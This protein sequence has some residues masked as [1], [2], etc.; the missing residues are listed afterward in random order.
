VEEYSNAQVMF[1]RSLDAPSFP[2]SRAVVAL[3][4]VHFDTKD[5]VKILNNLNMKIRPGEHVA[6]VGPS[7]CGKSTA[8]DLFVRN[9]EPTKGSIRADNTPLL[10]YDF[11]SLAK[12]TSIV[13]QKPVLFNLSLRENLLLGLRSPSEDG[14]SDIQTDV[15]T[16]AFD[17]LDGDDRIS[18]SI[19]KIIEK[20]GLQ[21]DMLKKAF[22]SP[23]P[24]RLKEGSQV[25]K[26]LRSLKEKIAKRLS[27][28]DPELICH[29][30]REQ[31]LFESSLRE[32]ILFGVL[33]QDRQDE[34]LGRAVCTSTKE[35]F[36]LLKGSPLLKSLLH[37]GHWR[38]SRDHSVAIRVEQHSSKL[39][40]ILKA[41]ESAADNAGALA[42]GLDFLSNE[43]LKSFGKLKEKDK[44]LL[45]EI[46]L[47]GNSREAALHF[48]GE[49]RFPPQIV[50]SRV[51]AASDSNLRALSVHHFDGEPAGEYL[52]LG[53]SFIGGR[54][55]SEFR[56][57]RDEVDGAIIDVMKEEGLIDELVLMGLEYTAGEG[58]G[59]LSGGQA[60][61]IAIARSILKDPSILLMDEAT[62]PLD[63]KSQA[64]V[65]SVIE[66]EF[67][68]RT[69]IFI[70]HRISTVRNFDRILVFDRGR[71]VQEG[72]YDELV[73]Q[74]GL[75]QTLVR[76]QEGA[77]APAP[78]MATTDKEAQDRGLSG[79]LPAKSSELKR[80][81]AMCPVF[82]NLKI[83][84]IT[85]LERLAKI[86][87]CTE[88]RVLFSRGDPADEFFII[89]DGEVEFIVDH[90]TDEGSQ[91]EIVDTYGPGQS[92]GELALFGH[93]PRTLGARAKT[94]LRLCTLSR[95]DLVGLIEVSP[96]IS[97]AL[98]ET[99]SKRIA[100]IRDRIY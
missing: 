62:A 78:K 17:D 95:E 49:V 94:D 36:R 52:S 58:G 14:A 53:E 42:E 99:F 55:N 28:L 87:K 83:E 91:I 12:E 22:D 96:Q 93:V 1:T 43:E 15:G 19:V 18:T 65:M 92:F 72:A 32:N 45:L 84:Q 46:A 44:L 3:E 57:A 75:F 21:E 47:D 85:L 30:D 16:M 35:I 34:F 4:D 6:F 71:I 13:F 25:F 68:D 27:N 33:G 39:F 41:Y 11:L 69:V 56:G 2:G 66:N 97:I 76:Q 48:E 5:G 88:D 20:V 89:L 86:V 9:I 63:Q 100:Q 59:S 54:V 73:S 90:E 8:L 60:M 50:K 24:K 81:I 23:V 70:T 61:K 10:K 79:D 31:Y 82:S 38:F 26:R 7:G 80:I 51:D 29:F 37:Y 64:A 40:E 74:E 67:R 98:L 77:M